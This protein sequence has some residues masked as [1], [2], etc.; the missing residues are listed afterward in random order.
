[1]SRRRF[2]LVEVVA[3]HRGGPAAQWHSG[4]TWFHVHDGQLQMI[5]GD[6]DELCRSIML[7]RARRMRFRPA[8]R[9]L[10]AVRFLIGG[11]PGMIA[12]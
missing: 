7:S 3:A 8:C 1:M 10:P 5:E 6:G 4:R 2:D 9:M 11:Q 12:S